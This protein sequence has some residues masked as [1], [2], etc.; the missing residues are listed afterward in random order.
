M[1]L[2]FSFRCCNLD[3]LGSSILVIVVL[4]GN[5]GFLIIW[6]LIICSSVMWSTWRA[7]RVFWG[8]KMICWRWLNSFL[9]VM[10]QKLKS[11]FVDV[12]MVVCVT[13]WSNLAFWFVCIHVKK[14]SW[15]FAA[16]KANLSMLSILRKHVA[17]IFLGSRSSSRTWKKEYKKI[18][19]LHVSKHVA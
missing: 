9:I 6:S 15:F 18:M 11:E 19:K 7:L 3:L 1:L 2:A 12:S 17:H 10:L 8:W 14:H 16:E 5:F 4:A 13:F